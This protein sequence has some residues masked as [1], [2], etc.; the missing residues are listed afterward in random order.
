M[1]LNFYRKFEKTLFLQS[2]D[3]H[4]FTEEGYLLNLD[5]SSH[6][7]HVTVQA[8]FNLTSLAAHVTSKTIV[9]GVYINLVKPHIISQICY[10][11]T[12]IVTEFKWITCGLLKIDQCKISQQ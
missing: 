9:F 5:K 1:G 3:C 11:Y 7:T 6:D 2:N 8:K 10:R 12:Y 4:L